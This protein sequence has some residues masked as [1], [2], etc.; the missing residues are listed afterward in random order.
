MH[1]IKNHRVVR[2]GAAMVAS[3]RDRLGDAIAS[4]E[5]EGWPPERPQ[6]MAMGRVGEEAMAVLSVIP[7]AV[8]QLSQ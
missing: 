4:A 8:M 6:P 5:N 7:A 1:P 3:S 2:Q